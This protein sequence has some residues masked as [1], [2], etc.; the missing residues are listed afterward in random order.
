VQ[1]KGNHNIFNKIITENFPNLEKA[2][3][4]QVQEACRTPNR[5]DQ[6][7]TTHGI[8]SLKQQAQ[9]IEKEY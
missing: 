2:M 4:I 9:R 1:A 8:L 6:N 3:P 5:P 7:R